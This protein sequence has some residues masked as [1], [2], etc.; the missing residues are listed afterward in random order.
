MTR[1]FPPGSFE[2]ADVLGGRV[3]PNYV[4]VLTRLLAAHAMAEKL[5][6]I[7]YQ[8]ALDTLNQPALTPIIRKNL[9]EEQKHAR[10]IYAAL[11]ELGLSEVQADR[12]LVFS[13]KAPSFAAPRHFAEHSAGEL[14]LVMATVSL[15]M[16]GLIMIGINY[17]E[18]SYA[19][20]ARAADE[21]VAEEEE[22]ELFASNVL[23]DAADHFGAEAVNR[24]LR[25]WL[26]LAV[27][28]FGPPGSGFTF[29]CLTYGLKSRDNQELAELYLALLERRARHAGLEL[30]ALTKDYPH[31]VA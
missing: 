15:D 12:L 5:T 20:H 25:Q 18:S 11:E 23:R 19:P 8:R 4:R 28:F 29:D 16:T 30:P 22:H 26:P 1:Q 2:A 9:A 24:A 31:T 27:N 14:D 3:E 13:V 10:L 7:G 6:A 17:K 21:I